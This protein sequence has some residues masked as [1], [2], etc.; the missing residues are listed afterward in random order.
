M[1]KFKVIPLISIAIFL[2]IWQWVGSTGIV[3][4]LFISF[5]TAIW[6][7]A[8]ELFGTG[9]IY[10]HL[11]ISAQEFFIGYFAAV[12]IGITLGILVGWY[13][14][15]YRMLN[16]FINIFYITPRIALLPLIILWLGI[17][18]WSKVLVVF[19]GAVFPILINVIIAIK[20]TDLELVKVAKSFGANDLQTFR[21]VALPYSTPF[22]LAGLRLAIGRGVIGI[23]IAELYGPQGGIGYLLNYYGATFQTDK[24]MVTILIII[25]FGVIL[26]E[27]L[28]FFEKKVESWRPVKDIE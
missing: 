4:P 27:I 22:I 8:K 12:A 19:L 28:Q 1:D 6:E 13:K 26:T 9:F 23:I 20:N 10:E 25:F 16:P 11:L 2:L 17:G 5:P 3:N 24:L 18:L 15:L 14:S 7:A 21:T